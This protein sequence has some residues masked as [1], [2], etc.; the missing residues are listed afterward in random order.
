MNSSGHDPK[1]RKQVRKDLRSMHEDLSFWSSSLKEKD[2]V[3]LRNK[4][5]IHDSIQ[6]LSEKWRPLSI[7][8]QK[9]L[10]EEEKNPEEVVAS[11]HQSISAFSN[12][13]RPLSMSFQQFQ[14]QMLPPDEALLM[15]DPEEDQEDSYDFHKEISRLAQRLFYASN[16]ELYFKERAEKAIHILDDETLRYE[17][18]RLKEQCSRSTSVASIDDPFSRKLEDIL[19]SDEDFHFQGEDKSDV[20]DFELDDSES[21]RIVQSHASLRY[22]TST[23]I[24]DV[25]YDTRNDISHQHS[26]V[27]SDDENEIHLILT[28]LVDNLTLQENEPITADTSEHENTKEQVESETVEEEDE[29]PHSPVCRK[30]SFASSSSDSGEETINS[31]SSES[32]NSTSKEEDGGVSNVENTVK[33]SQIV[34]ET[35]SYSNESYA[36]VILVE[37]SAKHQRYQEE[38]E[39]LNITEATAEQTSSKGEIQS[40]EQKNFQSAKK[41]P[42][43]GVS[44]KH[45]HTTSSKQGEHEKGVEIPP[46]PPKLSKLSVQSSF[47]ESA[48]EQEVNQITEENGSKEE[49]VF[50]DEEGNVPPNSPTSANITT[51]QSNFP[52]FSQLETVAELPTDIALVDTVQDTAFSREDENIVDVITSEEILVQRSVYVEFSKTDEE[53]IKVEEKQVLVEGKQK[54]DELM[55]QDDKLNK[56]NMSSRSDFHASIDGTDEAKTAE[57]SMSHDVEDKKGSEL[58]VSNN[59]EVMTDVNFH[60]KDG[61]VLSEISNN[62]LQNEAEIVIAA[63]A[64]VHS[65]VEESIQPNEPSDSASEAQQKTSSTTNSQECHQDKNVGMVE[66]EKPIVISRVPVDNL[67]K[68]DNLVVNQIA[69]KEEVEHQVTTEFVSITHVVTSQVTKTTIE[70]QGIVQVDNKIT[71]SELEH[72][73]KDS[74]VPILSEDRCNGSQSGPTTVKEIQ[75]LKESSS[76]QNQTAATFIDRH[77]AV[78]KKDVVENIAAK[79]SV[80]SVKLMSDP[81]VPE[82]SS[83]SEVED[84]VNHNEEESLKIKDHSDVQDKASLVKI[85]SATLVSTDKKEVS[86]AVALSVADAAITVTGGGDL[87]PSKTPMHGNGDLQTAMIVTDNS[88]DP[89]DESFSETKA[90]EME[91]K[92]ELAEKRIE[93][94]V[95]IQSSSVLVTTEQV[96]KIEVVEEHIETNTV[97]QIV[98]TSETGTSLT[99]IIPVVKTDEMNTEVETEP[100][101]QPARAVEVAKKVEASSL[102]ELTDEDTLDGV[103]LIPN[104]PFILH[105]A[106]DTLPPPGESL[107]PPPSDNAS[108]IPRSQNDD[109]SQISSSPPTYNEPPVSLMPSGEALPTPSPPGDDAPIPLLPP[110][111]APAPHIP[112]PSSDDVPPIPPSPDDNTSLTLG[113]GASPIP[114][115]GDDAPPIPL[116]P[117][118]DAPPIPSPPGDDAPPIPPPPGDDAP[119]IPLPPGDDAT[120]IHKPTDDDA[121]PTIPPPPGDDAPSIPPPPYDNTSLILGDGAS[122]IPPPGDDAPPIPLPP[123]D[124]ATPIP[125][126]TDDDAVPTIPPPPDNDAPSIP[127]PP[128][129][130]A[131][132]IPSPPGDEAPPIPPPPGDDAPPIPPPGDDA[133][134]QGD[135]A[136]P[137]PPPPGDEAALQPAPADEAPPFPPPTPTDDLSPILLLGTVAS[138][139]QNK[140]PVTEIAKLSS[141]E[142]TCNEIKKPQQNELNK[143]HFTKLHSVADN[144]DDKTESQFGFSQEKIT[145]NSKFLFEQKRSMFETT[146]GNSTSQYN[147][148]KLS[149]TQSGIVRAHLQKFQSQS[150]TSVKKNISQ[151]ETVIE[152]RSHSQVCMAQKQQGFIGTGQKASA[153]SKLSSSKTESH[154]ASVTAK[155]FAAGAA[156]VHPMKASKKVH[157]LATA[158]PSEGEENTGK[159]LVSPP[160]IIS[161]KPKLPQKPAD[162]VKSVEVVSSPS[163]ITFSP[164][165]LSSPNSTISPKP[166]QTRNEMRSVR[167]GQPSK[168]LP[169]DLTKKEVSPIPP[170]PSDGTPQIPPPPNDDAPPIP[171]PPNDD[172]PPIPPPP[173]DDAPPVPPLPSDNDPPIPPHPTD[174]APP[175]PPLPSDGAPPIP[176]SPTENKQAASAEGTL[177]PTNEDFILP[178]PPSDDFLASQTN[179]G[180]A[181]NVARQHSSTYQAKTSVW[182]PPPKEDDDMPLPPPPPDLPASPPAS[183]GLVS[184]S[185][186]L[187]KDKPTRFRSVARPITKE[188][189]I[190]CNG[191]LNNAHTNG[192]SSLSYLEQNGVTESHLSSESATNTANEKKIATHT[193]IRPQLQPP[194]RRNDGRYVTL[195]RDTRK[196]LI[197]PGNVASGK[198]ETTSKYTMDGKP[199]PGA[200]NPNVDVTPEEQLPSGAVY[201]TTSKDGD[202][203]HTDTYYPANDQNDAKT[204]VLERT[205]T[206]TIMQAPH[207]QGI[208][209]V[210]ENGVPYAL[211]STVDDSKHWYKNMFKQM[212]KVG[213]N[214]EPANASGG[215]SNSAVESHGSHEQHT[216]VELSKPTKVGRIT[217]Y[218]PAAPYVVENVPVKSNLNRRPNYQSYT[219]PNATERKEPCRSSSLED[220]AKTDWT[221]FFDDVRKPVT[222]HQNVTQEPTAISHKPTTSPT[223]R[224]QTSSYSAKPKMIMPEVKKTVSNH[225]STKHTSKTTEELRQP[226]R[227]KFDF[228]AQTSKELSLKKGQTIIVTKRID[229]NWYTA[230]SVDGSRSGIVPVQYVELLSAS[231][232]PE[233][234]RRNGQAR[235]KFD[236]TGSTKNE[237]SF[238]KGDEITILKKVDSNW[239]RGKLASATGIL[240]SVYVEILVEPEEGSPRKGAPAELEVKPKS[241]RSSATHSQQSSSL[242]QASS[243]SEPDENDK[244]NRAAF[245]AHSVVGSISSLHS[246]DS[247]VHREDDIF[248]HEEKIASQAE[249][250]S[251]KHGGKSPRQIQVK[252]H[253]AGVRIS[254]VGYKVTHHPDPIT[255]PK[256]TA[257]SPVSQSP[258]DLSELNK[259]AEALE[260]G[261][262][263]SNVLNLPSPPAGSSQ[264]SG[265]SSIMTPSIPSYPSSNISTQPSSPRMSTSPPPVDYGQVIGRYVTLYAYESSNDDELD[266]V[267][268]DIVMVVETCDDGWFVG[269]CQ[270]TGSFGTFPGNYVS[271]TDT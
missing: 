234:P 205:K 91:E 204:V 15:S 121:V 161:P 243:N 105:S 201:Q 63:S 220:F 42:S 244:K 53:D 36:S 126:P 224:M 134:H 67:T 249:S 167:M 135:D 215:Q 34:H 1:L 117:G 123:V 93:T 200:N 33:T 251:P 241:S 43:S 245:L 30:I 160:P 233:K 7:S 257:S 85:E 156:G 214:E 187:Q 211:R 44:S 137:I 256:E 48:N 124:D 144:D 68:S 210:S 79:E 82:D 116:P 38:A 196:I 122:P 97:S 88:P 260:K 76:D 268:G 73:F 90:R 178:P 163:V 89:I 139:P 222:D 106:D 221:E 179:Q 242:S 65:A 17:V 235:A 96:K 70:Q 133:P 264:M 232:S 22:E 171:P 9:S 146:S 150:D 49:V 74:S 202:V 95:E 72:E 92:D 180:P 28:S 182:S 56:L 109:G 166:W 177:K 108:E 127:S 189:E 51:T 132:P 110:N 154:I 162:E 75:G 149:Q 35:S 39:P 223:H 142:A 258:L 41:E 271:L 269:T 190:K 186:F 207:H 147:A 86:V 45:E 236:F 265:P 2:F 169:K 229:E 81:Q 227:V 104:K 31:S 184:A 131:P 181:A 158:E 69:E 5:K 172:A 27:T 212:H 193:S 155:P 113:D 197:K 152:K 64:I 55:L 151:F 71:S 219:R 270:R 263:H 77:G 24:G 217:D 98:Q 140:K 78:F 191:T 120:P 52:M 115:P 252:Q 87:T 3:Q 183:A 101:A 14:Q 111:D 129:D 10:Q 47:A 60:P 262:A 66:N 168:T 240:P 239:Y 8:F 25:S 206:T 159:R 84:E 226:A 16:R 13:Y 218:Q 165:S 153:N 12:R 228:S 136:P 259:V 58:V 125:Q 83:Q 253:D 29:H 26:K 185:G 61:K 112:S 195:L 216:S 164:K 208:G 18:W 194:S 46:L 198:L 32:D 230:Q 174:N 141:A 267:P 246:R 237:L 175:I 54:T 57:E 199:L 107:P 4:P 261:D 176:P 203:M 254:P 21:E 143:E 209:P 23:V 250:T 188:T 114:P 11:V 100:R 118:D 80:H 170:P 145:K 148:D 238:K 62:D 19:E 173:L 20:T 231:A 37:T 247:S 94:A 192:V 99:K 266:L 213:A 6:A 248:V 59:L 128:R 130:E 138:I 103:K 119:H 255:Y 225:Q 50:S 40:I 157:F 102:A